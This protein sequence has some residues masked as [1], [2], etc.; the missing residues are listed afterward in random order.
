M[1]TPPA[2]C[3]RCRKGFLP[4][5]LAFFRRFPLCKTYTR[6][7][8]S[9]TG[10]TLS[11]H[12]SRGRSL[13]SRT[14]E[15]FRS[16]PK[17]EGSIQSVIDALESVKHFSLISWAPPTVVC[18]VVWNFVVWTSFAC[19]WLVTAKSISL[20]G[21]HLR[22]AVPSSSIVATTLTTSGHTSFH[23]SIFVVCWDV[24]HHGYYNGFWILE[25]S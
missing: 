24:L 8:C 14:S 2:Q 7:D 6:L 9:L 10:R 11:R 22:S 15:A 16:P 13:S 3:L 19:S 4:S 25:R 23:R 18:G 21:V 1:T 17:R 20:M 12:L 5:C